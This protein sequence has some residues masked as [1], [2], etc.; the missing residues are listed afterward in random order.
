MKTV[1]YHPCQ[2]Q[3]LCHIIFRIFSNVLHFQRETD[4]MD[5]PTDMFILPKQFF[6]FIDYN[7]F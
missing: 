6:T 2:D 4:S 1:G 7:N 5:R 3:F